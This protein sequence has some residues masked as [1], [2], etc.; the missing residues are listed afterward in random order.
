MK[1]KSEKRL[2]SLMLVVINQ[3]D[4]SISGNWMLKDAILS[5]KLKG[6]WSVKL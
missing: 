4:E 5:V 3:S 2:Y 1:K 6:A